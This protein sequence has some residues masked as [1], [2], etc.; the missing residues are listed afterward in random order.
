MRTVILILYILVTMWAIVSIIFHGSRPTKSVSWVFTAV[1]FPF[2]GP[3][4]YYLFGVN[5]RKFKIFR[6]KHSNRKKLYY[7]P[8][9]E[10]K[11]QGFL[12][13]FDIRKASKLSR[14]V[15]SNSFMAAYTGNKITLLNDGEKTFDSIFDAIRGAKK[16]IHM[17]YY[18]I[19]QGELTDT[20]YELFKQ[21][22]A[23]GIQVR[24]IYD[25]LGSAW[26]RG[27]AIR[28]FRDIGVETHS[29]MPLRF[30]NMLFTLNYRNHRKIVVIDGHTGFTGGMNISDKYIHPISKL[31]IWQ[32]FHVKL[33]GPVVNSLHRVFLQ[34]YHTSSKMDELDVSEYLQEIPSHGEVTAQIVSSGPD[35]K[36]PAIMQQYIAM[37]NLAEERICI[38][39]P[40]FIPGLS[41][42]E[43]LKIAALS[44]VAVDILVPKVSDS[45]MAKY[46]MASGFRELLAVGVKIYTRP[47]F[48]HSKVIVIDKEVASIGSGNFDYR[49]FEH[50]FETNALIYDVGLATS[51]TQ[52]FDAH[53]TDDICLDYETFKKRPVW[54][55]FLEGLAKFFSPLL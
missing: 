29:I 13:K 35:S 21:K 50:N 1:I 12:R 26:L 2:A 31:G 4:L 9:E 44:G 28:R 34:D 38:A 23:E 3:L 55:K 49:S 54:K 41:V 24:M 14:L 20:F 8:E 45:L 39:N 48:S 7:I 47:D 36:Q 40:Y 42:L 27:K 33:E 30:G 18:I 16:Y 11:Q 37:I 32:D 22:I 51:I 6:L 43:A 53:C 25:S 5:R 46:S 52:D 17:Q 19:E 15:K 10:R